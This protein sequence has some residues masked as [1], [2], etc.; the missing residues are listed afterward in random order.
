MLL[1]WTVCFPVCK[2]HIETDVSY[3]PLGGT[4]E[5]VSVSVSGSQGQSLSYFTRLIQIISCLEETGAQLRSCVS[6][7][8]RVCRY[9]CLFQKRSQLYNGYVSEMSRS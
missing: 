6:L 5:M 3:N 8:S 1:K 2:E 7:Y 9:G 4:Q